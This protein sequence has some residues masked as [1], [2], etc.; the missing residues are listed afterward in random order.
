MLFVDLLMSCSIFS[1]SM[2]GDELDI[3]SALAYLLR[4]VKEI[5]KLKER[6]LSR[7][8]VYASTLKVTKEGEKHIYQG[9]E[10]K[11][12]SEAKS[13]FE[14]HYRKFCESVVETLRTRLQWS[15]MQLLR[16]I[17]FVLAT[18]GWEKV[19]VEDDQKE[20]IATSEDD[21]TDDLSHSDPLDAV[22]RLVNQFR[23]TLQKAGANTDEIRSEFKAMLEYVVQFISLSTMD[24]KST[25][26]RLFNCP[27]S[28]EWKNKL[29]LARILFSL[30]GSN[31]KL[32]RAF[33][34]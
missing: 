3:V 11:C 9:Q 15:D 22:D 5:Q 10:L 1:K 24:Y 18:Q 25:W 4:T 26:W 30:P 16:D 32:E 28:S 13:F 2:Q 29:L 19:A 7:W 21:G 8:E 27:N 12:F 20:D 33:H 34:R 31:G 14:N 6:S 23:I 17:I